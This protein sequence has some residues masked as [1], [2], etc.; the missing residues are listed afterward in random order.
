M[1]GI[2]V[3]HRASVAVNPLS[4]NDVFRPPKFS[5]QNSALTGYVRRIFQIGDI[6]QGEFRQQ[7]KRKKIF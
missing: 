2:V 1:M 7:H 6:S 3:K 5:V 4:V